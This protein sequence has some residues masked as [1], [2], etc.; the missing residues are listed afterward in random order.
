MATKKAAAK[1]TAAR[2]T[3]ARK[4]PAKTAA[5]KATTHTG[6]TTA[7]ASTPV[8]T[9]AP[10]A[11]RVD[12]RAPDS[13]PIPATQTEVVVDDSVTKVAEQVLRGS[14][15]WGTGRDLDERVKKAGHD[16][17]AVRR[18]I[19]RLRSLKNIQG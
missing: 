19:R 4:S 6:G 16:P 8:A 13:E 11:T 7:R 15:R 10:A 3:T 2:K 1:K 12:D 17:E 14:H 5:R 18:E 9:D